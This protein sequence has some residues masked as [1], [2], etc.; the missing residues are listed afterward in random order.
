MNEK[1]YLSDQ[2]LKETIER[3]FGN[4][5]KIPDHY[6][7]YVVTTEENWSDNIDGIRHVNIADFLLMDKF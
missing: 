6:P 2:A 4:L 1:F 7:K 5:K 3:E